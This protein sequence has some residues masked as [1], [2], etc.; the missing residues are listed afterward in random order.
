[1]KKAISLHQSAYKIYKSFQKNAKSLN[2]SLRKSRKR[3]AQIGHRADFVFRPVVLG[4]NTRRV[5]CWNVQVRAIYHHGFV[6]QFFGTGTDNYLTRSYLSRILTKFEN[7]KTKK[8]LETAI[9]W[10]HRYTVE[11]VLIA[12]KTLCSVVTVQSWHNY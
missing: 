3:T 2:I 9:S 10:K 7:I 11:Y 5:R 4:P 8:Q 12:N 6:M 1:M